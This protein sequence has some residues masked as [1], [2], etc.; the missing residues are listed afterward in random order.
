[1]ATGRS[2]GWTR[3][4]ARRS[5]HELAQFLMTS[6]QHQPSLVPTTDDAGEALGCE[7]E[8]VL[9]ASGLLI[10][11][12]LLEIRQGRSIGTDGLFLT[13]RGQR[14]VL[15]VWRRT[16]NAERQR[17]IR[18]ALLDWLE[19]RRSASLSEFASDP[20]AAVYGVPVSAAEAVRAVGWLARQKL[21]AMRGHAP[22]GAPIVEAVTGPG[23]A[24]AGRTIV[25]HDPKPEEERER[26]RGRKVF[27]VHGRDRA[28]GEA[29][30]ELL[31]AF[32]L[33]VVSWREAAAH[34]GGGTPDTGDV[35]AAGLR[36]ADAVVVLL[37]PDD[38]GYLRPDR[39][40]PDDDP[41]DLEPAGQARLNVVFEAG[42]ATA[43]AKRRTVLVEVG[44]VRGMADL[45]GVDVVR[46]DDTVERRRDLAAR[47]RAAGLAVDQHGT[48]W[49][50]AGSFPA[51]VLSP[52]DLRPV[53]PAPGGQ[54]SSS[55]E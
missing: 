27:L 11:E 8:D 14:E 6:W 45:A 17:D 4:P 34:A 2:P 41:H 3:D 5:A 54:P 32:D 28:A 40:E 55:P 49:R 9:T 13:R 18:E 10:D 29:L 46:V 50:T 33:E 15:Q 35:V 42:I 24:R 43:L 38:V 26:P 36:L 1:M 52:A 39:R 12:G 47:L 44:A 25:R 53:T 22:D 51:P 23:G 20:R 7:R 16:T 19:G 31:K 30:A 21:A 37:T 48:E